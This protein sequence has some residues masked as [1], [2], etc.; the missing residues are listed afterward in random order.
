VQGH[1]Q[2]AAF[3]YQHAVERGEQTV[4]GVTVHQ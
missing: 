3:A 4:V 2:D 1:I